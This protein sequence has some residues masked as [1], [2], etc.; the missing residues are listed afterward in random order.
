MAVIRRLATAIVALALTVG[1]G[2]VPA[3]LAEAQPQPQPQ[4]ETP[5][6]STPAPEVASRITAEGAILWDPADGL[7]LFGHNAEEPRRMASTTKIM[8]VLLALEAG[9]IDEELVV[10]QRAVEVGRTPGA[11]SLGLEPGQT[12]PVRSAL[13]GLVL[14]SG[15]DAAVAVA[16]HVAGSEAAFVQKMN[17]RAGELGLADTAFLDVSGLTDDLGHHSS[18]LDLARLAAVAM[19]HPAF[20]TWAGAAV[21][22]IPGLGRLENRNVLLGTFPGATGVKTGYTQLAGPCLVASATRDGRTLYAVVLNSEDRFADAAA[23]LDYGFAAFA[24]PEPLTVGAIAAL[25]R[26]SDAE[27]GL[28]TDEPLA[29]TVPAGSDVA[30]RTVLDPVVVRP[31]AAGEPLGTAELVVDGQVVRTV[32]LRAQQ[33]VAAPERASS[34]A[35]AGT[36]VHDTIRAFARLR[37]FR[38]DVR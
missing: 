3:P 10:S 23:L 21:L 26:W 17:A 34:G 6:A 24:R 25:Y 37:P 16:E 32:G 30:W 8:T 22:D 38:R 35:V 27:V 13:A 4:P 33:P 36:A 29:R 19:A 15:N 18:P 20:A 7:V 31:V 1:L 14:Q 5:A 11:A 12:L 2:L 28:V 9:A